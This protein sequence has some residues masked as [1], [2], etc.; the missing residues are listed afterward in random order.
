MA[1]EAGKK[2]MVWRLYHVLT[3]L[4]TGCQVINLSLG[5]EN[6]WPEDAMAVVAERLTNQGVIGKLCIV[7]LVWSQCT[8]AVSK[9][10]TVVGV[11]GNQGSDGIYSQN[12]PASGKHVIA[13][14]SIDNS[15]YLSNVVQFNIITDEYFRKS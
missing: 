7:V 11:A 5:I 12:S 9:T 4:C 8:Y 1:Y 15:F 6:S 10:N 2:S 14:A 3:I 13:A